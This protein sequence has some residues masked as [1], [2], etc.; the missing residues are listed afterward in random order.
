L[1]VEGD[2]DF[3]AGTISI[4]DATGTIHYFEQSNDGTGGIVLR[5]STN[6]EEIFQV[7]SSGQ[8]V[9]FGVEHGVDSLIGES[10]GDWEIAGNTV[11]HA[12]NDGVGSGLDA[13]KLV[14]YDITIVPTLYCVTASTYT[15][16]LGGRTGANSK[17]ASECGTGYRFAHADDE[18]VA[19]GTDSTKWDTTATDLTVLRKYCPTSAT[20]HI[21]HDSSNC[22]NWTMSGHEQGY[23]C[24]N[25]SASACGVAD[26]CGMMCNF[27]P[28]MCIYDP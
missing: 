16:D 6:D 17:C 18:D 25:D 12:G 1:Q 13:D 8:A 10:S 9:R 20:T 23:G 26:S 7:R 24:V 27:R 28:L 21:D 15:G 4:E 2:L 5:T 14:G 3:G 19:R 22:E 11:W